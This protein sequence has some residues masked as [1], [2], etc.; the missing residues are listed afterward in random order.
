MEAEGCSDEAG[1]RRLPA[2]GGHAVRL[3][4][5]VDALETWCDKS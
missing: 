5:L 1:Q 4:G 2:G 3:A